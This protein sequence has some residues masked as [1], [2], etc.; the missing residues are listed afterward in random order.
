M[1]TNTGLGACIDCTA[2]TAADLVGQGAGRDCRAQQWRA[3]PR[4]EA[5]VHRQAETEEQA[6][7]HAVGEVTSCVLA[8]HLPESH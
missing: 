2:G 5:R 8:Y 7:L 3:K 1:A 4:E 6:Q